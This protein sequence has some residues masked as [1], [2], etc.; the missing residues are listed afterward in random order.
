M[1]DGRRTATATGFPR[2]TGGSAAGAAV[3]TVGA[4]GA[5]ADAAVGGGGSAMC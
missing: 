3:G 1:T 2:R 5:A 4:H